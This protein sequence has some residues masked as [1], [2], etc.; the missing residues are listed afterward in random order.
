MVYKIKDMKNGY[1]IDKTTNRNDILGVI[2]EY[3]KAQCIICNEE[4][5]KL[6]PFK[7][8][9]INKGLRNGV[10]YVNGIY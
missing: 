2:L 7:P 1:F 9:T 5:A 4:T 6:L 10:F 8:I 3:P